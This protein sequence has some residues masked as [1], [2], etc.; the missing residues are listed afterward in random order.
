M[1]E[2][3]SLRASERGI[4]A[5][6]AGFTGSG[7]AARMPPS[8]AGWAARRHH[9]GPARGRPRPLGAS[10]DHHAA[11]DP[12]A[13][14]GQDVRA[15]VDGRQENQQSSRGWGLAWRLGQR[16]VFLEKDSRLFPSGIAGIG[17]LPLHHRH[18]C[19]PI[20]KQRQ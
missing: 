20:F 4:L 3:A 13:Q 17:R 2:R 1:V 9:S 11:E 18:G 12:D 10:E 8:L 7:R 6:V 15:P 5:A 16:P 19:W 14:S